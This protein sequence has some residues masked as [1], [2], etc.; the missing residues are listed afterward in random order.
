DVPA[1]SAEQALVWFEANDSKQYAPFGAVAT[2]LPS[3]C[4]RWV[5]HAMRKFCNQ[6]V[7]ESIGL[8]DAHQLRPEQFMAV[9]ASMPGAVVFESLG[10]RFG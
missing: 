9:A 3:V 2:A 1:W 5:D 7:G 4:M 10:G 6:A 8:I